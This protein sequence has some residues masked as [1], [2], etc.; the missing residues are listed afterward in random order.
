M[1]NYFSDWY[2]SV[3]VAPDESTLKMRWEGVKQ[4][5]ETQDIQFNAN[6]IRIVFGASSDEVSIA[7][8][9]DLFKKIDAN[10]PMIDNAHEIN[11]LCGCALAASMEEEINGYWLIATAILTSS[12]YK[13]RTLNA[14]IDLTGIACHAIEKA[15]NQKRERPSNASFET[16]KLS[17]KTLTNTIKPFESQQDFPTAYKALNDFSTQII[18]YLENTQKASIDSYQKISRYISN[19]DEELNILWWQVNS[20][21]HI[22]EQLFENISKEIRPLILG[23]ETSSMISLGVEPPGLRGI[24]SKTGISFEETN[25][26]PD[27]INACDVGKLKMLSEESFCPLIT[28]IYTAI[29]KALETG[30]GENWLGGWYAVCDLKENDKI[31]HLDLAIQFHREGLLLKEFQK[32]K[33]DE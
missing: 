4:L 1:H 3:Q 6:L 5:S 16:P 18:T 29:S 15:S 19:R 22:A 23:K 26:I 11:V 12:L 10:F 21:S 27:V 33:N 7:R 30:G 31:S 9:S 17:K 2:R 24:L 25:S 20:W 8:I 14:E 28:P 13:R 32:S